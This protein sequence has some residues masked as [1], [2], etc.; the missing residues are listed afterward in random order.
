M[1]KYDII[2]KNVF[3][4]VLVLII[5]ILTSCSSTDKQKDTVVNETRP[6]KIVQQKTFELNDGHLIILEGVTNTGV[7][8]DKGITSITIPDSI[9]T[10]DDFA[11]F[12]NQITTLVI[13]N[14]VKSIGR[15]AFSNNKLTSITLPDSITV[16]QDSVFSGNQLTSITIP[17]SVTII[18]SGAFS[19]NKL[20]SVTIPNSVT[21]IRERAFAEN[22]LTSVTI[23]E[24]VSSFNLNVFDGSRNLTRITIGPNVDIQ[25]NEPMA[26][27][28]F[29]GAYLANNRRAGTYTFTNGQWIGQ[30]R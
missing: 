22:N 11:F 24:N 12:T 10:I 5:S 9:T 20:T 23:S 29:R 30:F 1:V 27:F 6:E 4:M 7:F 2:G 19:G 15:G 28:N 8:Q 3:L 25:G 16:I 18:G 26:F 21:R 13:P 17:N 14:S